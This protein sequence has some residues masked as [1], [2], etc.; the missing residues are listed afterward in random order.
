MKKKSEKIL[1]FKDSEL[2]KSGISIT[3]ANQ[4]QQTIILNFS[5]KGM[6]TDFVLAVCSV[7]PLLNTPEKIENILTDFKDLEIEKDSKVFVSFSQDVGVM[8][9]NEDENLYIKLFIEKPFHLNDD[10]VI[11]LLKKE[12]IPETFKIMDWAKPFI[13]EPISPDVLDKLKKNASKPGLKITSEESDSPFYQKKNREVPESSIKVKQS[14]LKPIHFII[15]LIS[16]IGILE[17]ISIIT[18]EAEILINIQKSVVVLLKDFYFG[19]I[20]YKWLNVDN[21]F[22]VKSLLTLSSTGVFIACS[23]LFNGLYQTLFGIIILI[24][25]IVIFSKFIIRFSR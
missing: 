2:S 12:D 25:F 7:S 23:I 15:F 3:E 4:S 5:E 16:L 17:I 18:F 14:F 8:Y 1:I 13:D 6:L 24:I 19:L 10:E 9:E 21:K 20:F 22:S 11:A